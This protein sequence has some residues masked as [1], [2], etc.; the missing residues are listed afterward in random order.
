M[1]KFDEEIDF[2]SVLFHGLTYHEAGN[3]R[4]KIGLQ[5]LINIIRAGG[6]LSRKQVYN[7]FGEKHYNKW[8]NEFCRVNWNGDDNVS[9]CKRKSNNISAKNSEAF[10][11]FVK[12]SISLILDSKLL[13]DL[14]VDKNS[15]LEDGEFQI[16][17]KIDLKYLIGIA[18]PV[19]NPMEVALHKKN[20]KEYS[21]QETEE[22]IKQYYDYCI[23]NVFKILKHYNIDLPIYSI[24]DGNIIKPLN[25]VLDEVYGKENSLNI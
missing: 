10:N 21:R 23:D 19:L 11:L 14:N 12:N 8:Q 5:R 6:I 3:I 25:D 20:V 7:T 24:R 22:W 9:V 4:I 1:K 18:V 15:R 16:K 2:N 17:D 13:E